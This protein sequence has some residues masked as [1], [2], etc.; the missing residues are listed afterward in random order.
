MN[1]F[2]FKILRRFFLIAVLSLSIIILAYLIKNNTPFIIDKYKNEIVLKKKIQIAIFGDSEIHGAV[3]SKIL[4]KELNMQTNNMANGGQTVY[5][6]VLKI[7]DLLKFNS[8]AVI[9]FDYGSN[10]VSYRGDMIRDEGNLFEAEAFKNAISNNFQFMSFGEI[11]FFLIHFPKETIQSIFK[12]VFQYNH[13]LHTGVDLNLISNL[14]E[15]IANIKSSIKNKDSIIRANHV[16]EE[17][18]PFNK[19]NELIENHPKSTFIILNP[20]EYRLNKFVHKNDSIKW[21]KNTS[22]LNKHKN[23]RILN[24]RDMSLDNEDFEDFSHL[25][26]SG[27]N[28]FSK[29]L[30][31]TL[32]KIIL[33]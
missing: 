31:E 5:M 1:L 10:D 22:I 32:N 3:D 4:E 15:A 9:I 23:T 13:I 21:L 25:T 18:F 27:K 11:Y 2:I 6:N 24:F 20:P 16:L 28:K 19:L 7:R 8:N 12:G 14:N 29:E 33:N 26:N 30:S 17:N